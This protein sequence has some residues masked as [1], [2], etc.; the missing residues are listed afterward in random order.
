MWQ[1]R[2]WQIV[3]VVSLVVTSWYLMQALHEL[4]H[5]LAALVSGGKVQRVVL[6][7]LE[8][9]R[10][11]VAPNPAAGFV[12]W[13]G[14]IVGCLIPL[15][16]WLCTRQKTSGV[17]RNSLQFFVGWCLIANGGYIGIGAADGIG[18][19]GEMLRSGTPLWVMYLFGF[20]AGAAGLYLWHRLGRP[21]EFWRHPEW[22]S[23]QSALSMLGVATGVVGMVVLLAMLE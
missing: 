7:P 11:E 21:R 20:V 14:P 6:R 22:I 4:G 13:A 23:R 5:A 8:F 12:V 19:C 17:I 15:V 18:D 10:T 1:D 9:S 16:I 2:V 3:F